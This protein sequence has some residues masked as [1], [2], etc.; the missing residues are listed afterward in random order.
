MSFTGNYSCNSLRTGLATGLA[1]SLAYNFFFLPPVGTLTIADPQ[2]WAALSY[3]NLDPSDARDTLKEYLLHWYCNA[4]GEHRLFIASIPL[5]SLTPQRMRTAKVHERTNFFATLAWRILTNVERR[6]KGMI[7]AA[8][9]RS[10]GQPQGV[11]AIAETR[12]P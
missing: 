9:N 6:P 3:L 11:R 12:R 4:P 7:R 5:G 2:N 1:S 8:P 10:A